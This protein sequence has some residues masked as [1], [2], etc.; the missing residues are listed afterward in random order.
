[1][2]QVDA[3][4]IITVKL[5]LVLCAPIIWLQSSIKSQLLRDPKLKKDGVM[6]KNSMRIILV[7]GFCTGII[8]G[9]FK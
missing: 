7:F 6:K 2:S 8:S 9:L 1:M 4:M 5:G 3:E